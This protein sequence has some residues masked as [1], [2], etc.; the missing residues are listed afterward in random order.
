VKKH[1]KQYSKT[2]AKVLLRLREEAGFNQTQWAKALKLS[3]NQ[4][5]MMEKKNGLW[6][7]D[8][9]RQATA[10]LGTTVPKL[11]AK[12]EKEFVGE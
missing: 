7:L 4:V 1:N 6:R 10:L 8:R 5:W 12:V 2:V 9:I 11:F 3:S